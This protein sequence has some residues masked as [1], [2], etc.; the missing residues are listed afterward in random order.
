MDT[1]TVM[2]YDALQT[3]AAPASPVGNLLAKATISVTILANASNAV[4]LVLNGIPAGFAISG[5]P[6][7]IAGAAFTAQAFTVSVKDA[8]GRT[9]VGVYGNPVA[10][11]D[12]DTSGATSIATSGSDNP[13]AGQLLS[14][15]DTAALSYTGL[16]MLPVSIGAAAG[17]ATA[18]SASFAPSLQPIVTTAPLNGATPQLTLTGLNG[19]R[20]F[21]ASE[22]G[23]TNLPYNK[24]LT[25]STPGG[26]SS[27]GTV[28]PASGTAFT[29]TVAGSPAIGTCTLTLTDFA[30]GN[31]STM[32]LA[33][34]TGTQTYTALAA[35]SFTVPFGVTQATIV[36]SGGQGAG[37]GGAEGGS[38]TAT[39]PVTPGESLGVYVG[40]AAVGAAGGF[41]GGGNSGGG[42]CNSGGGGASDI[43]QGGN[44]VA[45]RVV[46]AGGGGGSGCDDGYGGGVGGVGGYF[47]HVHDGGAV[48]TAGGG[49]GGIG[50]DLGVAGAGG[51]GGTGAF[52]GS[53]GAS[54]TLALGGNGG[55][56]GSGAYPGLGGAGGGAGYYGA[57]G[58][59]GGAG[60]SSP[61]AGIG[62]GGGGGGTSFAEASA[63]NVDHTWGVQSGSGQVTISW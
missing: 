45:N 61:G 9:I 49:Q 58:G 42:G 6:A 62:G 38:V 24:S 5:V 26:C 10:L 33:Y 60:M 15:S 46:V 28:A 43:R 18:S 4:T 1:F 34:V 36:T 39:I 37:V 2:T 7:G 63:T 11:A 29:S 52:N 3:S 54:G 8:G 31:A 23:W 20:T 59:G 51:A 30:G 14:S 17:G 32:T 44:A 35:Q 47:M 56:G 25:V 55:A 50:A 12:S 16:A 40:G 41:N 57:G 13:P 21:T 48:T 27:I 22:A 53:A 19:S